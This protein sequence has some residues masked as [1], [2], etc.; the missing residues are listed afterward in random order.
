MVGSCDASSSS[1]A[2][3]ICAAFAPP[4]RVALFLVGAA[5]TLSQP[6]LYKT[7]RTNLLEAFGGRVTL[8]ALVK[9]GD[10][11]G[12]RS[13]AN[14]GRIDASADSVRAAIA[15]ISGAA[16]R[17]T[18][19]V[20]A[21]RKWPTQ[22]TPCEHVRVGTRSNPSIARVHDLFESLQQQLASRQLGSR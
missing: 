15:H 3:T 9:I 5:R 18:V 16:V 19:R 8:F 22:H 10:E 6:L 11:R 4:P 14:G 12:D 20:V 7:I 2:D 17:T 13:R 21:D 1:V